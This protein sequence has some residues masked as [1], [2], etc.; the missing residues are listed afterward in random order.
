MDNNITTE[1]VRYYLSTCTWTWT[2]EIAHLH[3]HM[4][5]LLLGAAAAAALIPCAPPPTW[6]TAFR[7]AVSLCCAPALDSAATVRV[8]TLRFRHPSMCAE[9]GSFDSTIR[10]VLAEAESC[11]SMEAAID[12]WLDR[13]DD[14][15]IP[16][17]GARIE[18][19]AASDP[20]EL[21]RLDA[22]S[23]AQLTEA[24]TV[25][26]MRSQERFE[27]SR[28][29]LQTLLGAGEIN[30]MDAQLSGMVKRGEIDAGFFYVLLRN[31]EDAQRDGDEGGVRLISHIH[32]RLQELLEGQ[33]DPALALL[34]KL[35]RLDAP[36]IR[37]NVLRHNLVPQRTV[38]LPDG[39]EM[40]LKSPAPA[41]VDPMEFASAIEGAIDKVIALPL[42][43]DA[44]ESTAEEIRTVA[45][46]ARAVVADA[47]DSE[48]LEAF[49]D[50]LTPAFSRALP[51][52]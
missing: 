3:A 28:D 11:G 8:A 30:K 48:M 21:E 33:A 27:Q 31:L 19:A 10:G 17:L 4:A 49:S 15:F 36:S 45:K 37:G 40:P 34:H 14:S 51:N 20:A 13:L 24:M 52:R 42:D 22:P 44:I 1:E 12:A 5:S 23:L 29:Q 38:K 50:A 18:A 7:P 16:M 6:R 9:D 25:L 47:Y 26:Q 41:M 35:T 43:R 46:E 32:T 2:L 39:S